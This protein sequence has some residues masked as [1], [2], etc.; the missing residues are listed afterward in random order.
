MQFTLFFVLRSSLTEP[1]SAHRR[2]QRICHSNWL[3]WPAP[4]S[5]DS[6]LFFKS[7]TDELTRRTAFDA[8]P[9]SGVTVLRGRGFAGL[10]L[11]MRRRLTE[12]SLGRRPYAT[13][14]EAVVHHSKICCRLAAMGSKARITV[15]QH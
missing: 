4:G 15:P 3:I 10:R 11:I 13:H 12:P 9:R 14:H 6:M 5:V 7:V 8:L 1:A 2:Y